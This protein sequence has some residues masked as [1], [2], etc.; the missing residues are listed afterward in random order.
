MRTAKYHDYTILRVILFLVVI[1]LG[2]FA[3]LK[4]V[5]PLFIHVA[6]DDAWV[7]VEA[8]CTEDGYRYK[9]CTEC[10]KEFDRETLHATGHAA[11]EAV[12]ENEKPHT[13]TEGGSYESVV[14]CKN[15]NIELSRD[16]VMVEGAHTVNIVDKK[17]NIVEATCTEGGSYD[18]V[19]GCENCSFVIEDTRESFTVDAL[20]HTNAQKQEN[21]VE[22]TCTENGSHDLVDYC[23]ACNEEFAR[24]SVTVD[25]LGHVE[26]TVKENEVA[27]SCTVEASYDTVVRCTVCSEELSRETTVNKFVHSGVVNKTENVVDPTCTEQGSFDFVEFC[28]DCNTYLSRLPQIMEP[29]GHKFTWTLTYLNGEFV[30]IG[31]CEADECG[32]TYDPTVDT[33]Y[34][35]EIVSD[36]ANEVPDCAVGEKTYVANVYDD[37]GHKVG[38]AKVVVNPATESHTILDENGESISIADFAL[39]DENGTYYNISTFGINLVFTKAD[40][41]TTTEAM[42]A[43]WDEN[44]F[45]YG[46]FKCTTCGSWVAVRVYNDIA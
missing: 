23:S 45:G 42:K 2:I 12:K 4:F 24:E 22:P 37:H 43:A 16:T 31:V 13:E 27:G 5:K 32:H 30:L 44:G 40:G 28:T 21:V 1:A 9:I 10:G 25:A 18:I 15:C 38:E 36:E 46:V 3:Y 11:A 20:G 29:T 7:T 41:Q 26:E 33:D 8:T 34:T 14:C 35:Y 17:Q 6:E 19:K 39:T